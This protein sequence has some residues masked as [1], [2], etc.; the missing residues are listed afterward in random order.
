[1]I[2]LGILLFFAGQTLGWFQ[3]NVQSFSEYWKEKALLSA[4][5]MGVPTSVMFWYGWRIVVES[6]GSAW[7]ARFIASCAGLII[8]P[9]LTWAILGE[10]MFT[11]KTMICLGLT[12][13]IMLIQLFY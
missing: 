4:V 10:S 6:T 3:L 11:P 1:M 9:I 8:F 13:I 7:S 5:V 12:I 2:Y